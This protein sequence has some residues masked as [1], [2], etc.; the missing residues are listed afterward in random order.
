MAREAFSAS[1]LESNLESLKN[2]TTEVADQFRKLTGG[3][4]KFGITVSQSV[5][6]AIGNLQ[7][8]ESTLNRLNQSLKR[9]STSSSTIG[10]ANISSAL[11]QLTGQGGGGG[12]RGGRSPAGGRGYSAGGFEGAS[13][14]WQP[15]STAGKL[16]KFTAGAL[17][18]AA[19]QGRDAQLRYQQG[20]YLSS[21]IEKPHDAAG[22]FESLQKLGID[23]YR[24]REIYDTM[25]RTMGAGTRAFSQGEKSGG[26][27][28]FQELATGLGLMPEELMDMGAAFKAGG[29]GQNAFDRTYGQ[30]ARIHDI[31]RRRS[32]QLKFG[33]LDPTTKLNKQYQRDAR[34]AETDRTSEL[35]VRGLTKFYGQQAMISDLKPSTRSLAPGFLGALGQTGKFDPL[36]A[37]QLLGALRNSTLAPGGGEAGDV[38]AM[39]AAGFGNPYLAAEQATAK[40]L[41]VSGANI[42][43]RDFLGATKFKQDNPIEMMLNQMVSVATRFAGRGAG[44]QG[45]ALSTLTGGDIGQTRAEEIMGMLANRNFSGIESN[46]QE[47]RANKEA[48]GAAGVAKGD[49]SF[50]PRAGAGFLKDVANL[51]NQILKHTKKILKITQAVT[52]AQIALHKG[53]SESSAAL[54]MFAGKLVSA[55]MAVGKF[56]DFMKVLNLEEKKPAKKVEGVEGQG[57]KL[58]EQSP[59]GGT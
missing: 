4:E 19:K 57:P 7:A 49:K 18:A 5:R 17:M 38:L 8:L 13:K 56:Y 34:Q 37:N 15:S 31:S 26:L 39:Q 25:A 27:Y 53:A 9:T 2:K 51:N 55:T 45:L 3:A 10:A 28:N 12:G 50:S 29:A 54:I 22:R 40:R 42:Q 43:R 11:G 59:A 30:G 14:L 36:V 32:N 23:A 46:L 35:M 41:G 47:I 52:K 48:R 6:G 44:V 33:T 58:E 21:L 16:A 1:I 20:G 24:S